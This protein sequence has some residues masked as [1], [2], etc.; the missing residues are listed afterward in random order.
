MAEQA[1]SFAQPSRGVLRITWANLA[2]GDTGAWFDVGSY[3][4][5]SLQV[6]GTLGVGGNLRV[7][8]TNEGTAA[9]PTTLNDPQGNA[10]DIAVA[11]MEQKLEVSGQIRPNIT[12][13]DGTTDL[14]M[15]M[16]CKRNP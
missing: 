12:A 4:D 3:G 9:N 15:V 16:H 8:G 1:Y 11:K 13:G 7:Q 2:N 6:F 5:V 10:L 14:T